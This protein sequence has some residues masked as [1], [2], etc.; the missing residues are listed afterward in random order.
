MM[1]I[2]EMNGEKHMGNKLGL[3]YNAFVRGPLALLRLPEGDTLEFSGL[4]T[5]LDK[6]GEQE[7]F[8]L[9]HNQARLREVSLSQVC[10]PEIDKVEAP[11]G[12][13]NETTGKPNQAELLIVS[14]L[15]RHRKARNIFEFGTFTGRSTYYLTHATPETRVTT[16]DLPP[17]PGRTIPDVGLYF[18]NSD[19]EDRITQLLTDSRKFDPTPYEKKMDFI[20]VDGDHSYEGVKNDT[21]K[22]FKMLA[23]GGAILWHDYGASSDLGLVRYFVEFTR[24]TP[25]FRIKKTSL[26]LH[27]DGVEPLTFKM[28]V[29]R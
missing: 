8:Q 3:L 4:E 1:G 6:Y 10:G 28:K 17:G 5:A 7:R 19:R 9:L 22:A 15:A 18:I 29:E 12:T 25:L 13:V 16:L 23:P 24:Q 11:Y 2:M 21:E 14:V 20:F 26:L 27:V